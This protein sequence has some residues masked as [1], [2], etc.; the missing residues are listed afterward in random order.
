[1]SIESETWI[2]VA[3]D[4]TECIVSECDW[5][6]L[7]GYNWYN[8]RGYIQCTCSGA[9]NGCQ[10]DSRF[11]HS[12]IAER[13][14]LK[15]P[16]GFMIDHINRNKLDNRRSNLRV[17]SRRLQNHNHDKRSDNTTGYHGVSFYKHGDGGYYAQIQI[18]GKHKHL[19]LFDDPEEASKTYQTAKLKRDEKE[20]KRVKLCLNK[21]QQ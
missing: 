12:I 20:I 4:G 15:I 3:T 5:L 14:G 19:G 10:T 1:M 17:A 7:V 2:I 11:M 18:N 8:H 9:R 21:S 16:E 13:M 6:F